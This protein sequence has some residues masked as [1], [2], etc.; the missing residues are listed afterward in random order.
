L[1]C[2]RREEVIEVVYKVVREEKGKFLSYAIGRKGLEVQY[3][4]G[5]KVKPKVGKLFAFR[6]LEAAVGYR[7]ACLENSHIY[8]C[9]A[10][11]CSKT[12][13]RVLDTWRLERHAEAVKMVRDFFR[14]DLDTFTSTYVIRFFSAPYGTVLCDWIQLKDKIE[15]N[16]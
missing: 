10:S 11:V 1:R 15:W 9:L 4:P 2:E 8:V 5:E 13:S 3:I 16:R 7:Q 6:T 14:Y 12:L